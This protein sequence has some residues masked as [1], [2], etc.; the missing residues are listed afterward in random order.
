MTNM[1]PTLI[2]SSCF[3]ERPRAEFYG[4]ARDAVTGELKLRQPCKGCSAEMWKSWTTEKRAAAHH[5]EQV[6]LN[7]LLNSIPAPQL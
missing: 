1:R 4:R 6:R 2:C 7:R 3:R 5:A